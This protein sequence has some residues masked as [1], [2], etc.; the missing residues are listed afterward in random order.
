MTRATGARRVASVACRG[1]GLGFGLAWLAWARTSSA[2]PPC[3]SVA[4]APGVLDAA[5]RARIVEQLGAALAQHRMDVCA[6]GAASIADVVVEPAGRAG[7]AIK[8][9]VRDAVTQKEI[10]R[11][12]D[13]RRLPADGRALA[14]ALAADELLRAS[15]AEIALAPPPAPPPPTVEA[16]LPPPP[17]VRA[18]VAEALPQPSAPTAPSTSTAAPEA[19]R[20]LVALLG[21]AEHATGGLDR[22]GVDVRVGYWVTPSLALGLRL[23]ARTSPRVHA[24]D[25]ESDAEIWLGGA[26]AVVALTPRGRAAGLE[27]LARVDGEHVTFVAH[28]NAGARGSDASSFAVVAAAGLGGYLRLGEAWSLVVEGSA[29]YALRPVDATDGG[30]AFTGLSGLDVG[31]ALGVRGAL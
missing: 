10:A 8:I 4:A 18:V 5:A 30:V 25:G 23:G 1:L 6:G 3:V 11:D 17:E 16:P 15:W 13:L 14:V 22:L 31:G 19:R 7:V 27:A 9:H 21:A 28:P 12:V 29:G 26:G 2:A 24:P 20:A